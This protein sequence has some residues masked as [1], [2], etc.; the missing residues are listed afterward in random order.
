MRKFL[1]V[2]FSITTFFSTQAQ[3][4]QGNWQKPQGDPVGIIRGHIFDEKTKQPI[5]FASIAVYSQRI[6]CS[7]RVQ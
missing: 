7:K 6:Q 5:E 1:A 4:P 3:Q 2:L